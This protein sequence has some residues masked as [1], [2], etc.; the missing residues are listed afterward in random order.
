MQLVRR[1]KEQRW[2]TTFVVVLEVH[3]EFGAQWS[4]VAMIT[5]LCR[6]LHPTGALCPGPR[7]AHME[8]LIVGST[9]R[10]KMVRAQHLEFYS[11]AI[12]VLNACS[13]DD[14]TQ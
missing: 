12:T 9:V 7:A 1:T 8:T 2:A 6:D 10:A 14:K 11:C 5:L 4:R 13:L 3:L